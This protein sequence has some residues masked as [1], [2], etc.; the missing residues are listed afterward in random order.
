MYTVHIGVTCMYDLHTGTQ[1]LRE[2]LNKC[3]KMLYCPPSDPEDNDYDPDEFVLY[4]SNEAEQVFNFTQSS[5]DNP[6][7]TTLQACGQSNEN[8][9]S[10][11]DGHTWQEP[12]NPR[13][14]PMQNDRHQEPL[15]PPGSPM[16]SDDSL[17]PPPTPNRQLD[18]VN[19]PP[20]TPNYQHD[21][22]HQAHSPIHGD[23]SMDPPSSPRHSDDDR[24]NASESED[25]NSDLEFDFLDNDDEFGIPL[26]RPA[27]RPMCNYQNDVENELD[28]EI[29][30]EW[31][32]RDSGP[33]I[34]PYSGFRQCLVDPAKN[35]PEDFFCALFDERMFTT[36][37][38]MT[39][40][41]AHKRLEGK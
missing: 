33:L 7:Y 37:A 15:D 18:P 35:K 16:H 17:D 29:G 19:P 2:K 24:F 36:M 32:E 28:Y 1:L 41:Y 30:W 10:S 25:N 26:Q 31:H 27:S 40:L 8:G 13:G 22:F 34:G 21:P 20:Q 3:Q 12:L 9:N 23:D 14:S 39:N 5:T 6:E 4:K 11:N 38:E